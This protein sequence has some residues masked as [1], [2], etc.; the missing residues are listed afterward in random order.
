MLQQ[1][2]VPCLWFHTPAG[3]IQIVTNYYKTILGDHMQVGPVIPLGETPSGN[4]EMC[5]VYIFGTKYNLMSTAN[6][7]HPFNDAMALAIHCADQA[8]IDTFWNYFT[9]EGQA[10]QC[11]WCIDKFGLRWQVLPANLAELMNQPNAFHIM[12]KQKKI[13]H[14]C[15]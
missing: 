11:G 1:K 3:S 5:E 13:T 2:I 7:H 4:T 12:M 8:E 9:T 14:L 10:V 15:R 6:Q